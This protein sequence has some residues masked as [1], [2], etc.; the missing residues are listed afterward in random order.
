MTIHMDSNLLAQLPSLGDQFV[1]SFSMM[2]LIFRFSPYWGPPIL[3]VIFWHVW[4]RYVR[5]RFIAEQKYILLEIRLPQETMK[6]PAAMQ[7]VLDGLWSKSGES[8]F[9]DRIWYGKV[10]LWYSFELVSIEG[11]VHMYVWV[12]E[13]FRKLIERSF[14]AHYPDAELVEAEDYSTKLAYSLETHES[15]GADFALAAPIGVPI[16]TYTDYKLDQTSAKEGEKVDPIS[17]V[18]EFLASMGKGEYGWL[19]ILVRAHK[20]EDMTFGATRNRKSYKELANSEIARIRN[21]PDQ[22][23]IFPD[24]NTGKTLSDEQMK[25]IQ[26]I[27]RIGLSSNHWDVGIRGIYIAE[28]EKF[29]GTTISG[30]LSIWQ[31][32]GSPGFNAIVPN[33]TRWQPIFDYPWQDFNGIRENKKKIQIIEAYRLRSWFHPP[34]EF[35]NFMMTSEEIATLFH[36]PGSVAKTATI[37]R[38]SSTR[39][40]AP[41]NIPR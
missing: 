20:V 38:I 33:G 16:R 31:P 14:Y 23:I 36:I 32:F 22:T 3:A 5:S 2:G 18:Y 29:D 28:K 39:A 35:K 34:Y 21:N 37:Q 24:G 9:I 19:Q 11:Q 27:N 1:A 7:A 41:A 30:L 12:R 13:A 4:L 17:H 15:F 40:Q 26:A 6:S 10:R 25:R 8:T